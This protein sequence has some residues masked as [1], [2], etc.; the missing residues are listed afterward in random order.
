METAPACVTS[1][2]VS[3][4]VDRPSNRGSGPVSRTAT[5][6][7]SKRGSPFQLTTISRARPVS[8]SI[9]STTI[10]ASGGAAGRTTGVPSSHS[11]R[12]P[13]SNTQRRVCASLR[14]SVV[15]CC[16]TKSAGPAIRASVR[17]TESSLMVASIRPPRRTHS[18]VVMLCV[19]TSFTANFCRQITLRSSAAGPSSGFVPVQRQISG[20]VASALPARLCCSEWDGL[21]PNEYFRNRQTPRSSNGKEPIPCPR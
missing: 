3:P 18:A 6:T 20:C 1:R 16:A 17:I 11:S 10:G 7:S 12:W 2:K 15:A 19:S 14:S 13:I 8:R 4:Y 5:A 9:R 21:L